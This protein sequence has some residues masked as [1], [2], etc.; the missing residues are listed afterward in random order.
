MLFQALIPLAEPTPAGVLLRCLLCSA[1]LWSG[2]TK[3]LEFNAAAALRIALQPTCCAYG[4]CR[5]R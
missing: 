3:L 2:V 4:G 1:Y 5:H